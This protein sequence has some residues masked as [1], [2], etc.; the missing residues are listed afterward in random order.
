MAL[1]VLNGGT[2]RSKLDYRLIYAAK[3]LAA[4]FA[5]SVVPAIMNTDYEK[6]FAQGD[7]IQINREFKG[8]VKGLGINQK[9]E[10]ESVE[11]TSTTF[12]ISKACY[13]SVSLDKIQEKQSSSNLMDVWSQHT[14][15]QFALYQDKQVLSD[16]HVDAHIDNVGITAGAQSHAFNLGTTGAPFSLTPGNILNKLAD[17]RSVLMEQHV[18]GEMWICLPVVF[19]N[20]LEKAMT[21]KGVFDYASDTFAHGLATKRPIRGLKVYQTDQLFPVIDG[22][23]RCYNLIAGT[24]RAITFA[25]TIDM[26]EEGKSEDSFSRWKRQAM[27]YDYKTLVPEELVNFYVKAG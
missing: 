10:N 15:K 14:G 22:T 7:T 4:H 9:I 17:V 27:V 20:M 16:V 18:D 25:K 5:K 26:V 12:E 11:I 2:P 21:D 23:D 3:T 19:I 24:K 6:D 8:T 1:P 13:V